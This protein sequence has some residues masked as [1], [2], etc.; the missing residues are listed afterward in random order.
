[1]AIKMIPRRHLLLSPKVARS[2]ER[3]LAILQLVHH[4]HV[5]DLKQVLQ[6]SSYIYFVSEYAEGGELYHL[7]ADRG[8][9]PESEAKLLFGQMAA[10]L[11]WCHAHHIWYH[12]LSHP[13][14]LYSTTLTMIPFCLATEI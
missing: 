6:D 14:R 4:P 9:L 11:A 2:V 7:L 5:I 8:R 1:M 13:P 10:A 12:F 3:E